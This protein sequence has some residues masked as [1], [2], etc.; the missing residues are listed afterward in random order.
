MVKLLPNNQDLLSA[1]CFEGFSAR[2]AMLVINCQSKEG[3]QSDNFEKLLWQFS[4]EI[5]IPMSIALFANQS[6]KRLQIVNRAHSFIG[7]NKLI[8]LK[9][10][11]EALSKS[12]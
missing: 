11:F 7:S 3:N 2:Q 6:I 10:L 4:L 1:N 12:L 9:I 8:Q 5:R